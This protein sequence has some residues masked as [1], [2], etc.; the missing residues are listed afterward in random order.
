MLG[1]E[2][3]E[4]YLHPHAQR[5]LMRQFDDLA[6][7]GN[8]IFIS[9]HSPFFLDITRSDRIILVDR[10]SDDDDEVCTQ[11]RTSTPK[12]LLDLRK[13]LHPEMNITL[14]SLRAFLRNVQSPVMSEA[15]FAKLCILV[16]GPSESE[17]LLPYLRPSSGL[18]S[19]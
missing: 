4:L 1:I 12:A 10:K 11:V 2:E 18:P 19:R 17:A 8:Q 5:S 7:A 14:A 13:T 3:P 16:E 6:S 15:F 9:S